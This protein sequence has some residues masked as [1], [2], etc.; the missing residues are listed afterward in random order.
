MVR[1]AMYLPCGFE[2]IELYLRPVPDSRIPDMS[3]RLAYIICTKEWPECEKRYDP[4]LLIKD[5]GPNHK[6]VMPSGT[7]TDMGESREK[8]RIP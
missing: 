6:K 3:M 7:G 4:Y 5:K 2:N 8:T 1:L